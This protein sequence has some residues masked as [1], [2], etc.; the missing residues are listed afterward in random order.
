MKKKVIVTTLSLVLVCLTASAAWAWGSNKATGQIT[1]LKVANPVATVTGKTEGGS[2]WLAYTVR[3]NDGLEKD[4]APIK[5]KGD[6]SKSLSFQVR[7]QGLK[8]V[9][10]CLW[11]NKVSSSDCAKKHNGTACQYCQKNGFHMEGR[12]D[13]KTGS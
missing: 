11:K 10:V 2:L 8:E 9:I 5:V 13:R 12:V 4:Y 6:F 7:P 3:W 1:G